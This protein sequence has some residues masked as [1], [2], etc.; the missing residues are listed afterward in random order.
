MSFGSGGMS[1]GLNEMGFGHFGCNEFQ[2]NRR[3]KSLSTVGER[4]LSVLAKYI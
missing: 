4:R 1:F 3:K 2:A